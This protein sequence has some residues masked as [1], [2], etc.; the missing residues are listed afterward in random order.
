LLIQSPRSSLQRAKAVA[1]EKASPEQLLIRSLAGRL[2]FGKALVAIA[3]KYARQ[4]WAMLAREV[5]NDA[6]A[7]IRCTSKPRWFEEPFSILRQREAVDNGSDHT[8]ENLINSSA[9]QKRAS[10]EPRAPTIPNNEVAGCGSYPVPHQRHRCNNIVYRCAVLPKLHYRK[11]GR[12]TQQREQHD[13][14]QRPE[15]AAQKHHVR[16]IEGSLFVKAEGRDLGGPA[17]VRL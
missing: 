16:G 13:D 17:R 2:P 8:G 11:H 7:C 12:A 10:A 5:D 4:A 14:R 3:N 6:H 9:V 15:S 1:T